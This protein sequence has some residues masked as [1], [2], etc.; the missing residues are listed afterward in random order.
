VLAISNY[1]HVLFS[2]SRD[3]ERPRYIAQGKSTVYEADSNQVEKTLNV[4]QRTFAV[5]KKGDRQSILRTGYLGPRVAFI[6]AAKGLA[7]ISHI[8]GKICGLKSMAEQLKRQAD[9][10]LQGFSLYLTT[11]YTFTLRILAFVVIAICRCRQHELSAFDAIFFISASAVAQIYWIERVRF[12][13]WK[14]VPKNRWQV[15]GR[16][17]V[18][19][20]ASAT[21]GPDKPRKKSLL[22]E[23][24]KVRYR[25]PHCWCAEMKPV[26]RD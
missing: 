25:Y 9:G 1:E 18:V 8:D 14:V 5:A 7:F 20:D 4:R 10:D 6:N 19:V 3:C 15:S 12:K 24:S 23:V 22:S 26:S 2:G 11:N 16:V 13:T 17:E 21:T